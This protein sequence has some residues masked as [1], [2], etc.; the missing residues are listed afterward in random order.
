[1]RSSPVFSSLFFFPSFGG[2]GGGNL[3]RE[4]A[5]TMG[6]EFES[7]WNSSGTNDV[8]CEQG[9]Y[10]VILRV[11]SFYFLFFSFWFHIFVVNDV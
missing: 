9:I 3:D 2:G 11:S 5:P 1:M 7:L 4:R 8:R 10:V 6:T